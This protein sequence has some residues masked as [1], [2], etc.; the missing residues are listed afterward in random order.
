PQPATLQI[1]ADEAVPYRA[2]AKVM[3]LATQ[4]GISQITF[5]TRPES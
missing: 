4:A 3:G 5:I 1:Q 2:V